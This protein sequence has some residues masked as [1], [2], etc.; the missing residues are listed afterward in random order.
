MIQKYTAGLTVSKGV[1]TIVMY[2]CKNAG[3]N[4]GGSTTTSIG[5]KSLAFLGVL[6]ITG[7]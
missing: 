2:H 3:A 4:N 7:R 1:F 6:T 5:S